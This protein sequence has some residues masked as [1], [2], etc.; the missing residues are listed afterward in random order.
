MPDRY[1][2]HHELYICAVRKRYRLKGSR[3]I[4][5]GCLMQYLHSTSEVY[6]THAATTSVRMMPGTSP[7]TEKDQGK[8][9]HGVRDI[10]PSTREE[11]GNERSE[12]R[13]DTR[14]QRPPSSVIQTRGPGLTKGWLSRCIPKIAAR[15][16]NCQRQHDTQGPTNTEIWG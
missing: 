7:R 16:S 4:L 11:R 1:R 3:D 14:S 6:K 13:K 9:C 10:V 5:S 8:L 2:I 15:Q 12:A